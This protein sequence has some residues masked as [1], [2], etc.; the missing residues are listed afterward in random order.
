MGLVMKI[1]RY[2]YITMIAA[3]LSMA[4]CDDILDKKPLD[5]YSDVDVFNNEVLMRNFVNGVYW[6]VRYPFQ[7]D[8]GFTDALTDNSYNQHG[9][10]DPNV[11]T[12]VQGNTNKDNGE[13]VT[14]DLWTSA[15]A[16]IRKT[17]LFF[18][19]SETSSVD[20]AP[21]KQM[22]GEMRYLR[23]YL[24]FD[25]LRWYG[26]VPLITNTYNI[27][28][29][30][31]DIARNS[32]DEV[33]NFIVSECNQAMTEL[34]STTNKDYQLGRASIES[35]MALKARTLLYIASPLFTPAPD[36]QKWIAARDANKAVMDLTSVSL[37]SNGDA[38]NAMFQGDN[39]QEVILGRYFSSVNRHWGYGLGYILFP[40]GSD[41]WSVTTPTQDLV[42]QYEL[43]NGKVPADPTSG[44]DPQNPYVGRDPRFYASI[45]YA[46]APFKDGT[47]EIWS[48][49][50]DSDSGPKGGNASRTGYNYRKWIDESQAAGEAN[51]NPWI[52]FRLS[53]FYLNY[54][55][56]QIALGEE[57][58][59]RTAINRVRAKYGMPDVTE[60][61]A[62]L[63]TRYRRERRVE[64]LLEDHYFFDMRRW[65]IGDQVLG[66]AINGVSVVKNGNTLQ[67]TYAPVTW[68]NEQR[69]WLDKMYFLPIPSTEINKSH[70]VLT[71]NPLY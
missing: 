38:Y 52:I 1:T 30:S 13:A 60:S 56:T 64:L 12:F 26:G 37:V 29:P 6:N 41:G 44:Y 22:T 50:K 49:G 8:D 3:A 5:S 62:D 63:V 57:G 65:K 66:K 23:A 45:L 47:Y 55:E 25:L 33:A 54:A 19:K 46:N 59:A 70:D 18:E 24:Y 14:Y 40:A 16:D 10:A 31:F 61:G 7:I 34:V 67:Y 11:R 69:R 43:T 2:T 48:G 68:K 58:E 71:Q 4:G 51:T 42:D 21:L 27:S 39:S 20:A 15:F 17:N 53:E 28:D 32:A 36:Q 35:A 9:S